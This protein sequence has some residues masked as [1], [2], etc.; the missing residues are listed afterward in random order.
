MKLKRFFPK[1]YNQ[2][3]ERPVKI[4]EELKH[5][6]RNS[7]S[8]QLTLRQTM[9]HF[10]ME[11][12]YI[13]LADIAKASKAHIKAFYNTPNLLSPNDPSLE[14]DLRKHLFRDVVNPFVAAQ[15]LYLQDR[16]F[17]LDKSIESRRNILLTEEV[18]KVEKA[19]REHKELKRLEDLKKINAVSNNLKSTQENSMKM[20]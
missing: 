8:V 11:L 17:N 7:T 14:P 2:I 15:K 19:L 5:N 18:K 13:S 6:L 9:K 4:P 20:I 1:F 12:P 16:L 3:K 10:R